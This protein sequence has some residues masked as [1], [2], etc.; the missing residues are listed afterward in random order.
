[1]KDERGYRSDLDKVLVKSAAVASFISHLYFSTSRKYLAG[2]PAQI[3]P[4]GTSLITNA[5]A[6]TSA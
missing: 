5:E 6:P 2:C 4:A 3:C 1:M